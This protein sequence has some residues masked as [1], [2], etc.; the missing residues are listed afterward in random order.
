MKR[1]CVF[2]LLAQFLGIA[3]AHKASDG[4]LVLRTGATEQ[5]SVS[6]SLSLVD[7]DLA[8][9]ALD[10][11]NDR[12]LNWAEVQASLPAISQ[13]LS[14]K[15]RFFCQQMPLSVSWRFASLEQRSDATYLRAS[16]QVS[17]PQTAR[18]QL[19]YSF[20][21]GLDSTHRLLVGGDLLAAVV[22]AGQRSLLELRGDAVEQHGGAVAHSGPALVWQFIPQ[23]MQHILSGAD[24]LAFLLAL[25]LPIPLFSKSVSE[26][27]AW[28]KLIKTITGFTLGHSLTLILVNLNM[29]AP[30]SRWVEAS[31]ALS[32]GVSA[33]AN[34][35]PQRWLRSDL[36]A[37][38]FGLVHG[39]GFAGAIEQASI[40][41]GQ[42]L[43]A[44]GG[45]NIGVE[46]G[47]LLVLA[48]WCVFL[49]LA[50]PL[51]EAGRRERYLVRW[52]SWSLILLSLYWLQGRLQ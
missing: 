37:L 1:L 24:H 16:A 11:D 31:I 32:I 19:E 40:R 10:S 14:T 3:W 45:F 6:L 50:A 33:A 42:R 49:T 30:E 41:E 7:V 46:F 5:I 34:L 26:S 4:Y 47:Q 39:L 2:L 36:L 21:D 51:L 22:S 18:L 13:L 52:G 23:G 12:Q 35:W 9:P 28:K 29:L 48:V 15:V 38:F 17:C 8:I 43:W 20:L 25:L 27:G 44:L